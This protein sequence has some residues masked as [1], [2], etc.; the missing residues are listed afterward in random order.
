MVS[1]KANADFLTGGSS[2]SIQLALNTGPTDR[3]QVDKE[4][5]FPFSSSTVLAS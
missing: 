2:S 4:N 1:F 3:F 5:V